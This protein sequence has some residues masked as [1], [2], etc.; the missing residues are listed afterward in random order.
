MQY[1]TNIN[2]SPSEGFTSGEHF[3][4]HPQGNGLENVPPEE[5]RAKLHQQE[6]N[7]S[8]PWWFRNGEVMFSSGAWEGLRQ[9]IRAITELPDEDYRLPNDITK[10]GHLAQ[11][12]IRTNAELM[13]L[14]LPYG[15]TT[16][17]EP[18]KP[19]CIRWPSS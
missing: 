1:V 13:A 19:I 5:L 14:L 2:D 16:I 17:G 11:I 10:W 12:L 8:L 9:A 7:T 15:D 4:S 3:P 18:E 6:L